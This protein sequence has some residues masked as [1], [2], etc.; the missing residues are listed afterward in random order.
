MVKDKQRVINDTEDIIRLLTDTTQIDSEIT[1]IDDEMVVITELV[2]KLVI[3]NAKTDTDIDAYNKKYEKLSTRYDKL[4]D[5]LEGLI[6]EKESKL[7]Q[8]KTMQTFINNLIESEDELADWNERIWMLMVES[9][10]VHRDSSITFK[11]QSG[12]TIKTN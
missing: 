8:K 10:V 9:A 12:V 6:T 3:E 7:G 2:N 11:F 1:K 5:Q 4:K